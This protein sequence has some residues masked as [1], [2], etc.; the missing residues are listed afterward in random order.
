MWERADRSLKPAGV[1]ALAVFCLAGR[2]AAQSSQDVSFLP[3]GYC[4]QWDTH[5]VLLH[6]IS[7]GLITLSYFCIPV[8]LIY[9][10][11]KRRDLPFNWIFFMFGGFIVSC[12]LTHFMEI[13][14]I[15]HA[16][17][18]LS[19]V[20]K[21]VTAGL[22]VMTAVMLVPLIPKAIAI[23]SPAA[24]RDANNELKLTVLEREMT[25]QHLR[26]SLHEREVALAEL[27]D[28]QSAVEELQMSQEMLREQVALLD[29]APVAIISRD[30]ENRI[31]YWSRGAEEL[32]GMERGEA[33]GKATHTYL[34]T[35][36]PAPL[37]DIEADIQKTGRWQGELEHSRRNGERITVASRWALLRDANGKPRGYLEINSNITPRKQAEARSQQLA[38]IVE[39]SADAIFSKDLSEVVL[40]WNAGAERM[41]GYSEAEA[42]GKPL[43]IVPPERQDEVKELRRGILQG[44]RVAQDGTTR[45]R[46]DGTILDVS[47]IMSP[48]RDARGRIVGA[49]VIARDITE[50]KR[51]EASRDRLAAVV[52]SSDDAII[53]KTLDGTITAWNRGAQK[54]FGYS[55]A[56]AVGQPMTML[57]PKG[58]M[59]EEEDILSRIR[60]GESVEHFE[61][62]RVRKDGSEVAVSA[63][64][65][66]IRNSSGTVIGASTIARDITERRQAEEELKRSLAASKAALKELADQKFALDQ[67]AIVAITDVQRTITYVNDKFCAIS[68]Y[69]RE[70]PI[71]KNHRILNS[72]HHPQAFF[73]E[74]YR[75]IAHGD[76]WHAEIRNRAKDGSIYLV[77]TTIVPFQDVDGKPRQYLAIRADITDRKRVEEVLQEQARVLRESEERLQALANGIPQLAW[78]AEADGHIFWYNQRWY[79]Y[80]GTT[81]QQ[82]EGWGWQSV[83]DAAVLPA[84]LERWKSSIASGAPFDMEFPLRSGDGSFRMFL[85]RIMP[86]KDTAGK[87]VRWFGT[88][89]DISERNQAAERQ[90][91]QAKELA[92]Q[93]GELAQSRQALESQTAM[94]Q[95][96]LDSMAEG[97]V[98]AD[99]NSRFVIWNNRLKRFWATA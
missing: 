82:M 73:Q 59:H 58:R 62:V 64:I 65:S 54:I 49:S 6:V 87:V 12:G 67:H 23:P 10:V 19:G 11:K 91:L 50:R 25:E 78:M 95:S 51:A 69:S 2:A 86:V 7:D 42:V 90:A 80:T 34:Q 85:T 53:S 66:P 96:V 38:A 43:M 3:H 56:E 33:M 94:L 57:F 5:I 28:R 44:E 71:G 29:L 8:A 4:Y 39:S 47:L 31:T 35:G 93:A 88:N 18:V 41:F 15:W 30:M 68:Q 40:S 72:G 37:P 20:L 55:A 84:V 83:H 63:T 14:T 1:A 27:A 81:A 74:M 45:R 26:Q 79:D 46:K 76:T 36:A 61:T 9:L 21:A 99:E 52:E 60:H 22:S 13:W 92:Q 98:A 48:L 70:D 17:Y 24:L 97:L 75:T 32:Y 77:D 16:T 89:T